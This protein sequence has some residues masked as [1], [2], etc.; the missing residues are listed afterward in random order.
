[1][2][3]CHDVLFPWVYYSHAKAARFT[4]NISSQEAKE[5]EDDWYVVELACSLLDVDVT[6]VPC[7]STKGR[8]GWPCES[9]SLFS[10]PGAFS[11][12]SML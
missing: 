11:H 10:S 6:R 9:G 4:A 3:L 8:V 5:T 2:S 1:M 12:L 7:F